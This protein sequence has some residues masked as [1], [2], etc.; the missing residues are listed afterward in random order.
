MKLVAGAASDVGR[1]RS[2][3]EDAFLVDE[4]LQLFA[5]ADGMGGHQAGEVA[6]ATALETLRAAIASGHSVAV[7]I[8]KANDAVVSKA[9][10]DQALAG[11]GTTITVVTTTATGAHIGHV[12]DS[13]AYLFRAGTLHQLTIDH[14]FV[15]QLVQE[16]RLTPE[17]AAVHPQ[18]SVITRALGISDAVE[19][20]EG[21]AALALGDRIMLCSDGLSTMIREDVISAILGGELDPER[22][23]NLLVDAANDAGGEDNVTAVVIDVL[24]APS[25]VPP[26]RVAAINPRPAATTPSPRA[27]RNDDSPR[28]KR[29]PGRAA[30]RIALWALPILALIGIAVGISA[31]YAKQGYFVTI[32]SGHVA[33]YRGHPGGLLGFEPAREY[34]S[35]IALTDLTEAQRADLAKPKT[36]NSR[37]AADR[38]V[39]RIESD[40]DARR[41]PA[42]TTTTTTASAPTP[43]TSA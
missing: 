22:A 17:Q 8:T 42:T 29:E 13:R 33:V 16:G 5:V 24:D 25:V 21:D 1:V 41:T 37:L 40:V 26:G 14:S 34:Q 6:S 20:D 31:W 30:M 35:T 38:Y 9:D 12:G 4:R 32:E 2:G 43:P 10:A 39:L 18:R 27:D 19:V 28:A 36:F 15:E 3:N 23:A 7:A 11:M